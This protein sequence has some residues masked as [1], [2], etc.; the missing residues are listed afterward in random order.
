MLRVSLERLSFERTVVL[1]VYAYKVHIT[2]HLMAQPKYTLDYFSL[3]K[4]VIYI[5]RLQVRHFL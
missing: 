1:V 2:F 3:K 4:Y 5:C